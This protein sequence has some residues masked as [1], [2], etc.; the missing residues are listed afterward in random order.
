MFL[1]L[2]KFSITYWVSKSPTITTLLFPVILKFEFLMNSS[3]IG[4][5]ILLNYLFYDSQDLQ[6][7][8]SVGSVSSK[9][10]IILC[11]TKYFLPLIS[12][13]NGL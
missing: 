12:L 6:L 4:S 5:K 9:K 1:S 10:F 8:R 11:K 13:S 2:P 3:M 7:R